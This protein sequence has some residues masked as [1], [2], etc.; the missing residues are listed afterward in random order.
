MTEGGLVETLI[1]NGDQ[2]NPRATDRRSTSSWS[3]SPLWGQKGA[4][5]KALSNDGPTLADTGH[6]GLIVKISRIVQGVRVRWRCDLL[7]EPRMPTL[8]ERAGPVTSGVRSS[9]DLSGVVYSSQRS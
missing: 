9:S 1:L 2:L 8:N 4:A 5:T 7:G 6:F 3:S